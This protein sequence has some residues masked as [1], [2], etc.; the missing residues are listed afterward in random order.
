MLNTEI[1]EIQGR[2]AF[3]QRNNKSFDTK[4]VKLL[5]QAEDSKNA[6]SLIRVNAL[7]Y[8]SEEQQGE[9][10]KLEKPLDV[11]EDKGKKL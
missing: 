3:L 11:L 7:K 4:F 9:H 2:L 1:K 8:K 10:K 6:P 5:K